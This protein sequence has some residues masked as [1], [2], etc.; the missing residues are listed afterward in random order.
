MRIASLF[1]LSLLAMLQGC[2][3]APELKTAP[4]AATQLLYQQHLQNIALI[5][6]FSLHARIGVQT[7]GK[8]F[9]GS[10]M[11]Q[12]DTAN[13]AITL[14]S[15]LG[16]QV[17][18]IKKT[19]N[20]V[21]LEEANGKSTS[22]SDTEALT[23]TVL[24]WRLPLAGLADWSLGRPTN[25]DIQDITLDNQGLVNTLK[26]D[27]WDIQYLKYAESNGQLLPSKILLKSDKVNLK[28]LVENW[29]ITAK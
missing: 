1:L 22:A 15:P 21:T 18:S 14:Y 8:G 28:L 23:Q 20:K 10:L 5:E 11:W 4:S 13:D 27:G 26:Q 9:S 7:E 2:V 29:E 19:S 24:G 3:S 17:A 6:Q 12:H 25:N 16:N